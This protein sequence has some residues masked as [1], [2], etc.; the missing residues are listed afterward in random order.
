MTTRLTS[1]LGLFIFIPLVGFALTMLVPKKNEDAISWI[2]Y[3]TVG[4][5]MVLAWV[6][7]VLWLI[8]GHPTF[9]TIELVLYDAES[10]RFFISFY[11]D[12]ITAVYLFVGSFLCFLVTVYSRWY[13]HRERGYKRFFNTIL[14]FYIT[15]NTINFTGTFQTLFIGHEFL[16]ILSFLLT[17]LYR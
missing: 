2:A 13:L 1:L 16:G 8:D 7:L 11:F 4:S 6:F 5:H 17:G 9:Q 12:K 10:Y 15:Y 3:L 14:F